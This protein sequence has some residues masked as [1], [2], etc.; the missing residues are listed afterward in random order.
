[1]KN[2]Q[3]PGC[4]AVTD[5]L[6]TG[7][8]WI[9]YC[10][11]CGGSAALQ[12]PRFPDE[13]DGM[14]GGAL[15]Q[16]RAARYADAEEG[17]LSAAALTADK[18]RKAVSLWLSLLCRYGVSYV[19]EVQFAS[20]PSKRSSLFLPTFGRFPLPDTDIRSTATCRELD[21]LLPRLHGAGLEGL[22]EELATLLGEIRSCLKNPAN[23]SDVFIAWHDRPESAGS[24]CASLADML[25]SQL[26]LSKECYSFVSFR[27]LRRHTV[28]HYEPHIYAALAAAKMMV[29]VVDD[30]DA[31]GQKFL[32]SEVQRFL[33]RKQ[34]DGNLRLY[35]CGMKGHTGR[36]PA[37][38][39]A[40]GLECHREDAEDSDLC[41]QLVC[42]EVLAI[43]REQRAAEAELP[44]AGAAGS[45]PAAGASWELP[46]GVTE[47]P[48]A[49]P[50]V[51]PDGE[52]AGFRN[53]PSAVQATAVTP[54]TT[55]GSTV[56]PAALTEGLARVRFDMAN[57][58]WDKALQRLDS[59]QEQYPTHSDPYLYMLLCQQRC[60]QAADLSLLTE[61]FEESVNWRFALQYASVEQKQLLNT[62]L[63][64]SK[65]LRQR[66]E[67][68]RRRVEA[69]RLATE[70]RVS[71]QL[72]QEQEEAFRQEQERRRKE[73]EKR[74]IAAEKRRAKE[75]ALAA[76][77]RRQDGIN[78]P[79]KPFGL[80]CEFSADAVTLK[81]MPDIARSA[82]W[83]TEQELRQREEILVRRKHATEILIPDC[84]THIG[85][86]AFEDCVSLKNIAIPE[87][88]VSIGEEAFAQCT[89]LQT[90]TLP[91][92]LE[93]IEEDAFFSCTSLRVINLPRGL[94]YIGMGAF[95]DC[96]ALGGIII[97][98]TVRVIDDETFS[99]C[100]GLASVYIKHGVEKIGDR[101]FANCSSKQYIQ[102]A[103]ICVPA[104]VRVISKDAFAR[105]GF[106]PFARKGVALV[107]E[108][109]CAE[110]Y[111]RKQPYTVK[112]ADNQPLEQ[113]GEPVPEVDLLKNR[114][115]KAGYSDEDEFID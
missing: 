35:F 86:R 42:N 70:R 50:S 66:R 41:A 19:E 6:F 75:A 46:V 90:V 2:C 62:H 111:F 106:V 109:S 84:I 91:S 87:G 33:Y 3:R 64:E 18:Q 43:L 13:A 37:Y 81:R 107:E 22:L 16:M 12:P 11:V 38:L 82:Y 17:F 103:L 5:A 23:H 7:A 88:V 32:A 77:K 53:R 105:S 71:E 69:E 25:N 45:R 56:I 68:E 101:A 9:E 94:R 63:M 102:P 72:R 30:Y 104:S 24:P 85:Y 8:D 14:A 83:A 67:Q 100:I 40:Q 29:I 80:Y 4:Q 20:V 10:P 61:A 55:A 54:R 108:G 65:A 95:S 48:E 58:R 44:S 57:K 99:G 96:T 73:Q 115:A 112:Y 60:Q 15:R 93:E 47:Q 26:A 21:D 52:T 74:R 1:M 89:A 51:Q 114:P 28:D 34:Q 92:T 78:Q 110:A 59:L 36:I 49:K 98:G 39:K 76:E 113:D 31:L 97:P 79:L 27:D